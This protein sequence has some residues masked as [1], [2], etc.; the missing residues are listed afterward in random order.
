[1]IIPIEFVQLHSQN[2][3]LKNIKELVLFWKSAKRELQQRVNHFDLI[4]SNACDKEI[5]AELAFC[6]FTPQSKAISC[7]NAV[8]RLNEKNLLYTG[9]ANEIA[10]NITGVRFHNNKSKYLV[11]ARNL[12]TIN[13]SIK[14]KKKLESFKETTKLRKWLVDN[15]KGFG[16]KEAGHF[17]RNIGMGGDLAILDRHILKNLYYFKAIKEIPETITE[18]KYIEIEKQMNK[19]CKKI[20]IP[21][22]HMDLLLW[23]MQ[24]GGIFK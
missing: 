18:K 20:K 15:I 24:T 23:C 8:K 11:Q 4:K 7:W 6:I 10:K 2:L 1:M 12:F 21:A 13:K 17:L 19:F 5:F 9:T 14:I 22:L 16:Y 3:K